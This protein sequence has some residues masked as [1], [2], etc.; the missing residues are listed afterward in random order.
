[1][2]AKKKELELQAADKKK[3]RKDSDSDSHSGRE[4]QIPTNNNSPVG[5]ARKE[6]VKHDLSDEEDEKQ[7]VGAVSSRPKNGV[8][9]SQPQEQQVDHEEYIEI[10]VAR[11]EDLNLSDLMVFATSPPPKGKMVQ[12]TI[13]RDKTSLAK[14]FSPKYH[15]YISVSSAD[16]R[17]PST[18]S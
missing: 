6:P 9:Q 8:P 7:Q 4:D 18:T 1:M 15:V 12:C 17:A 14:K 5:K 16:S 11:P 13:M 3:K 2:E 10:V